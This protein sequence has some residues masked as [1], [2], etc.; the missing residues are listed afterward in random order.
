M[1]R[2]SG[3]GRSGATPK[4]LDIIA[5]DP[6]VFCGGR[7][8]IEVDHIEPIRGCRRGWQLKATGFSVN[9]WTNFAPACARCN[10]EKGHLKL[11]SFLVKRSQD[12]K[13]A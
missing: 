6:C 8:K 10:R 7:N 5:K 2:P 11:L 13:L 3:I 9:H 12:V 4:Y 1:S